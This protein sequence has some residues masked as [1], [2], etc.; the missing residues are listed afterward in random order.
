MH[1]QPLPSSSSPGPDVALYHHLFSIFFLCLSALSFCMRALKFR[2]YG[3]FTSLHPARLCRLAVFSTGEGG[4]AHANPTWNEELVRT[5]ERERERER[6]RVLYSRT[7]WHGQSE[8][9]SLARYFYLKNRSHRQVPVSRG[10]RACL[11]VIR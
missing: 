8:T 3:Y 7:V 1:H 11:G 9:E 6:E 5:E 4:G 10:N 2:S